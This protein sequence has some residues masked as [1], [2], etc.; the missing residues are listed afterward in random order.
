M[1]AMPRCGAV[2]H[3]PQGTV[4]WDGLLSSPKHSRRA[5]LR[6]EQSLIAGVGDFDGDHMANIVAQRQRHRLR[7]ALERHSL[8]RR[9]LAG[10]RDH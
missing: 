8:N 9:R 5:R 6:R 1:A 2:Q 3:R 10:C 7:V 4:V